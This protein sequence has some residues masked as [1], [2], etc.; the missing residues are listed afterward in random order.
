V[1]PGDTIYVAAG[2]YSGQLTIGKSGVS[3]ALITIER[4]RST[5]IAATR[6]AGWNPA[7][8][9]QVI[10]TVANGSSGIYIYNGLG[11]FVTVD[12]RINAGWKINDSDNSSGVAIG[13]SGANNVTLRYIQVWGP[14]VIN[15]TSDVRGFDLTPNSGS[16]NNLVMQYCE[17]A[18]GGD[19][20]MYLTLANNAL[21]EYSSFHDAGAINAA[22]FHPNTI[23]CGQI[24]N[25]TFRYNKLYNIAVEGL[26]FGD[27]GNQNVLIYG[28]LFYQ[29][30]APVN[31][32]RA[33]EFDNAS[34]GNTGL[35]VYDNTF[36]GLPLGVRLDSATSFSNCSFENNIVYNTTTSFQSGWS[37]T[38]NFY[39]DPTSEANSIGNGSN[40]FMNSN[41]FDYHLTSTTG[42]SYPSQKG[43]N[44]R[45]PY[46][47]DMD[48]DARP[49]SGP[50][51]MGAYEFSN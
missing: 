6:A 10:Q 35:L 43:T 21:I 26:F 24:T 47:F 49:S 45:S 38:Y 34:G 50:W 19:S 30:S 39:S 12:G 23:Y 48:G 13:G 33:I 18:N 7:F 15:Q 31:S 8:D 25:S 36:V 37:S 28:N 14:G 41:G 5:D 17:V 44:L 3:G 16:M 11:S 22:T 4:V 51:D 40:P 46:N 32:G 27:S 20:C 42:A 2:T 9:G 29:G 1:N